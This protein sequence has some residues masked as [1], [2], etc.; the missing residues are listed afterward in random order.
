MREYETVIISRPEL[1]ESQLKETSAKI[2][3]II[4]RHKGHFFF[5]RNMGKRSLSYPIKKEIKG[6]YT[7]FDYAAAGT[8][9]RDIERALRIDD[10]VL[11]FLSVIKNE[12]VDVEARAAEIV[13]RGEDVAAAQED[14][15]KAEYRKREQEEFET[16]IEMEIE[17]KE[18]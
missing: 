8:T 5:A 18:A 7:C 6:V 12:C 10:T 1:T 16:E 13:A 4:E 11:R 17:D 14:P 2:K 15:A 3:S 9:V